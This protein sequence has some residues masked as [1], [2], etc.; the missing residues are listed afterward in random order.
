MQ[1]DISIEL[2]VDGIVDEDDAGEAEV[3]IKKGVQAAL[4]KLEEC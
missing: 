4:K 3:I 1:E 2:K